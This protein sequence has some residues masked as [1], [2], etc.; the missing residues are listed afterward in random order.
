MHTFI[1]LRLYS[2]FS[3]LKGAVK[4]EDL[5]DKCVKSKI[6]AVAITD[7]KNLFASLEFSVAAIK[8]G[9]QPIIGVNIDIKFNT[10]IGE[11]LLIASNATG[12]QNLIKILEKIRALHFHNPNVK[13]Q[14]LQN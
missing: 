6:P 3:M 7:H 11:L 10:I 1:H 5:I 12:F 14:N 8:N 9:I 13:Q 4:I 2:V